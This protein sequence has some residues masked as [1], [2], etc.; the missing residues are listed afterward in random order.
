[1]GEL[2]NNDPVTVWIESLKQQDDDSAR[3]IWERYFD[4]LIHLAR[5]KLGNYRREYDEEDAV[6]SAFN[7]FFVGVK[8]NRFPDLNDRDNLWRILVVITAR[9]AVAQK[10]RQFTDKRGKGM[11][12]GE[13][14]FV[15]GQGDQRNIAEF[16][17]VEPTE[18][19]AMEVAEQFRHL[20]D[21]LQDD[22]LRE[23]A[24]LKMEGHSTPEIAKKYNCSRRSIERKLQ[25]IQNK[26]ERADED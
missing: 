26:W 24:T 22:T 12:A 11:V 15:D 20:L 4:K 13:S 9:K 23:I 17:G 21:S 2:N 7:S 19:L 3:Q 8:Q 6:L 5:R 16:L 14:V 10:R 25:R 1:M 18:Q